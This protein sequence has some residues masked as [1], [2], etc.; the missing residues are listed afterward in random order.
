MKNYWELAKIW[1]CSHTRYSFAIFNKT[2]LNGMRAQKRRLTKH[3]TFTLATFTNLI[4]VWILFLTHFVFYSIFFLLWLAC[5]GCCFIYFFLVA[6]HDFSSFFH[7][8]SLLHATLCVFFP[9]VLQ[10]SIH[11]YYSEVYAIAKHHV[12]MNY[13]DF[14]ISHVNK[15][16][17]QFHLFSSLLRCFAILMN[18]N[19]L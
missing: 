2:V 12:R 5:S 8:S 16:C 19:P 11:H 14:I 1:L 6:I 7:P 3:P 4:L 9:C 17:T 10:N 13:P 18:S 15:I